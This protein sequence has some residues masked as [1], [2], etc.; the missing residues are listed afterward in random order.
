MGSPKTKQI[1]TTAQ[2]RELKWFCTNVA[3]VRVDLNPIRDAVD[4]FD[5]RIKRLEKTCALIEKFLGEK[6]EAEESPFKDPIATTK[7]DDTHAETGRKDI[8]E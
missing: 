1:L 4:G 2:A 5:G 7:A 3:G 8:S 6:I